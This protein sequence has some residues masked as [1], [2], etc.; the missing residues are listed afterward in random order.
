MVAS[1]VAFTLSAARR[2]GT[3]ESLAVVS[4]KAKLRAIIF[5][6]LFLEAFLALSVL[7]YLLFTDKGRFE[8]RT[9]FDIRRRTPVRQQ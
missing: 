9:L 7:N 5:A 1:S 2:I 4:A 6:E 3:W 8:Y